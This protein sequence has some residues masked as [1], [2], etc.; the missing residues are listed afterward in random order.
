MRTIRVPY[1]DGG[2][3]TRFVVDMRTTTSLAARFYGKSADV[4]LI[5]TSVG[6][7][8]R[9]RA[10]TDVVRELSERRRTPIELFSNGNR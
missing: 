4:K 2:A 9:T 7:F 10:P 6:A 8:R 1:E 3:L 5:G